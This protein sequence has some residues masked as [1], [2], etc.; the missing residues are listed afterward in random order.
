MVPEHENGWP[1]HLLDASNHELHYIRKVPTELEEM[2]NTYFLPRGKCRGLIST[3]LNSAKKSSHGAASYEWGPVKRIGSLRLSNELKEPEL[4]WY[5]ALS[6]II[7][8]LLLQPFRSLSSFL[9]SWRKNKSII[10]EL[11]LPWI[12]ERY[13]FPRLSIATII[14][15]L[16]YIC[17]IGTELVESF[18]RHFIFRKSAIPNHVSSTF[19]NTFF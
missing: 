15:I 17:R 13:T 10:Y 5:G 7:T 12:S 1:W 3:Y 2:I 16:G 9:T 19:S 14:E 11:L 6:R 4:V 18:R 8:V